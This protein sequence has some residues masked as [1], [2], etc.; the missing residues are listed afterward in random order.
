MFF[1]PIGAVP[2]DEK[3]LLYVAVTRARRRLQCS[4]ML[5]RIISSKTV[6]LVMFRCYSVCFWRLGILHMHETLP[7]KCW[8]PR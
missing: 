7:V 1:F 8:D 6:N 5:Y 2:N 3:N 4:T